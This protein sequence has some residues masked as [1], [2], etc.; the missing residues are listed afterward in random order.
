M[1][2]MARY[3]VGL[4][5]LNGHGINSSAASSPEFNAKCCKKCGQPGVDACL[6]CSTKIRGSCHIPGV[7]SFAS[8]DV[9]SFCHECGAAYPWTERRSAALVEAIGELEELS[10]A[11]RQHLTASVPDVLSDT[12]KTQTATAR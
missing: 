5:C 2:Q 3:D 4:V 12:P 9:P 1:T 7:V 6:K 11:E 8:W 10:D